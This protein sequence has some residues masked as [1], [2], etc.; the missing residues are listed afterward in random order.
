MEVGM[1]SNKKYIV[2]LTEKERQELRAMVKKGRAAAYKIKHANILL[3]TDADGP[4][5]TDVRIAEAFGCHPRTVEDVLEV[6]K[7]PYDPRYPVVNMDERPVQFVKETRAPMPARPGS[8]RRYDYEYERAGTAGVFLFT[9]ALRGWRSVTARGRRTAV[10]WAEEVRSLL[11]DEYPNAEIVI[12]VCDN[13]N[14]HKTAS[15]YRAFP[16]AEARRLAE[17]LEIHYTHP[18]RE[19]AQHRGVRAV[20]VVAPVPGQENVEHARPEAQG[21]SMGKRTQPAAA[22]RRLAIHDGRR[23]HQAKAALPTDSTVIED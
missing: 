13:L 11:D 20:G 19:P 16:P 3:K 15:L 8:P 23:P 17:R 10:D 21:E 14:T 7:R 4:A 22:R 12:L 9:E 18:A 1:G 5:W 2:R 6:Y